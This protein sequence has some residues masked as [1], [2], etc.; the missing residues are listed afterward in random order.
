MIAGLVSSVSPMS[1]ALALIAVLVAVAYYNL[2]N[3]DLPPGP[4]GFPYVGYWPFLR[5]QDAHVQMEGFKKKYGDI[6]SFT[7]FG[8]LYINLASFKA[9]RET[10]IGKSECFAA[11]FND[12]NVLSYVF[13][14]GRHRILYFYS[15]LLID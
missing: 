11:R 7:S 1:I 9:V 5:T 8:R 14:D 12:F 15:L 6:F 3:R 13:R 4:I 2:K 10:H